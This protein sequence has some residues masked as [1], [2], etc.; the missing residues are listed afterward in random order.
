M[1]QTTR[2]LQDCE[3]GLDNEELSWWPL[4]NPLTDGNDTATKRLYQQLTAAWKWVGAVSESPICSPA[5]TILNIGQFLDEDLTGH[6]W[7]M[8]QWLLAY[9][10]GLQYVGE[11][12]DGRTWRPNGRCFTLQ[13]SLLVDAFLEVTNAEVMEA[14][15]VRCWSELPK[16]ILL[17]RDE[18]AF[19]HIIS[20]LDNLVQHLPT[21]KA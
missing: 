13:I 2:W 4:V 15:V 11:A 14:D 9:A 8:Q 12:A 21:R 19:A 18:G 10:H 1:W 3:A 6:N 7:S 16:T 17:Q 5:P 20:Y